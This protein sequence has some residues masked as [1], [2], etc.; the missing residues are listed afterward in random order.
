MDKKNEIKKV[1]VYLFNEANPKGEMF[2]FYGG[3]G[4]DEYKKMIEEG[5]VDTPARLRL[6]KEMNTGILVDEA[7]NADPQKLISILEEIGFFVLTP[8]QL[9][10]EAVKMASVAID[11]ENF[12]DADIIAEAERRGLKKA[13]EEEGVSMD[14]LIDSGA[15]SADDVP[16]TLLERFKEDNGSLEK[17]ELIHLGK[18]LKL[19]FMANW[20]EETMIKKI[21][22]KLE[23]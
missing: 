19:N 3:K 13:P 2:S 18:E 4:S 9:K 22:E 21:N 10:A 8:E 12:S 5:W 6:P 20:K 17:E 1:P 23:A 14:K 11:M 7:V 16:P 15:G